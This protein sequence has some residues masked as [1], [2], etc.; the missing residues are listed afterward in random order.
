M[1]KT[2]LVVLLV[3]LVSVPCAAQEIEPDGL[4][5]IEGTK[6]LIM[7]VGVGNYG[8][9]VDDY[10]FG[11]YEGKFYSSSCDD[12]N[13]SGPHDMFFRNLLGVYYAAESGF[14]ICLR[15]DCKLGFYLDTTVLFSI[16][17]GSGF[18]L[19]LTLGECYEASM[20]MFLIK[21]IMKI[22]DGWTPPVVK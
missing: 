2:I 14:D 7:S 15:C 4:F 6:W 8:F 3:L 13:W 11:F 21:T 16:G 19:G 5:S 20:R 10:Y 17:F 22:E 18:T 12:C 9:E 1:K